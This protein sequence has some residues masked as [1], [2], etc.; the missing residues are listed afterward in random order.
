M[1]SEIWRWQGGYLLQAAT[2]SKAGSG[3]WALCPGGSAC[4]RGG[5]SVWVGIQQCP[6]ALGNV[7]TTQASPGEA[8]PFSLRTTWIHREVRVQ[9]S[10]ALLSCHSNSFVTQKLWGSPHRHPSSSGPSVT[11][12]EVSPWGPP[13]A[14]TCGSAPPRKGACPP[15]PPRLSLS[16]A[17]PVPNAG[18]P[19]RL[20]PALLAVWTRAPS[21]LSLTGSVAVIAF[22]RHPCRRCPHLAS[23]WCAPGPSSRGPGLWGGVEVSSVH[24]GASQR[25]GGAALTGGVRGPAT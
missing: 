13:R 19:A 22:P 2:T 17:R 16:P 14:Q 10:Q 9:K 25:R 12:E 4:G 11:E 1:T 3:E 23:P 5:G 7:N 21:G 15:A 8:G 18:P 24:S 6:G 20:R